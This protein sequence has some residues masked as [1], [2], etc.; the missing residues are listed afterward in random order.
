MSNILEDIQLKTNRPTKG[1][2]FDFFARNA[3][4]PK[5][6]LVVRGLILTDYPQKRVMT[7]EDEN[8]TL[9]GIRTRKKFA[10]ICRDNLNE[11]FNK[12]RNSLVRKL[13]DSLIDYEYVPLGHMRRIVGEL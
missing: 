3:R 5:K 10:Y 4:I 13:Q 11:Q 6:A 12:N 2:I 1:L 8:R 7:L 9:M